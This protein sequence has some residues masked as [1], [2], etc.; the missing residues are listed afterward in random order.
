MIDE[1][2]VETWDKICCLTSNGHG[3]TQHFIAIIKSACEKAYDAGYVQREKDIQALRDSFERAGIPQARAAHASE[4]Q[5]DPMPSRFRQQP[6]HATDQYY[7]HY[8]GDMISKPV[9]KDSE[10]TSEQDD[11]PTRKFD[12]DERIYTRC[13]ACNNDTLKINNGHLLCTWHKCPDP[14]LIDKIGEPPSSNVIAARERI[15]MLRENKGDR[16][17]ARKK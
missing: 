2:A 1:I 10:H 6:P 12:A 16:R 17:L 8:P 13:P 7:R 5:T 4:H 15:G 11:V 14:T 3:E 9:L